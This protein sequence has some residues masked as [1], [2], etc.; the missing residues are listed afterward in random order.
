MSSRPTRP[1]LALLTISLL[2]PAAVLVRG[3]DWPDWRGPGRTGASPE[4][5]LVNTWSPTGQNLAWRVPY[6]GRSGPVVFGDRLYLQNTSGSGA[7]QQE[8]L[9]S[10]NADTGRLLWEHR[11]N[12]FTSDVPAHRVAWSSPVV[13]PT[14]GTVF[15]ISG[16]GLA[17]SLNK[18]GKVLWE[19]SL[20]EEYGMWTTHGGRMSTPIIEGDKMIVS[21]LVFGWGQTA[22]PAHRFIALDKT[23][24]QTI[25]VSS[26][27]GRPTD[28]IY[29]NPYVADVDGVRMFF[30][31]GSDGAMHALKVATGEPVWH[32]DVSKR[33]LNTAALMVGPDVIVTHS[34]ENLATSE[35]G[36]LAAVPA[37]SKGTLTDKDA[38][39]IVRDV[40]AGYGSPVSDGE[41]IYLVDNGGILFAF[42]VKTGKQ[43]WTEKL[44]TIQKSSPVLADGK[45]YVG[46]ENGKFYII[47]PHADKAEVL[48]SDQ[49][50]TEDSPEP[51]IGAPA[52]AR[53]RVYLT[54]MGATYA[55]GPKTAAGPA[56]APAPAAPA[57]SAPPAAGTP[58]T[59]L[60]TPTDLIVKPGDAVPLTIRA[61]DG[62]G[63]T[64]AAPA[65]E[66]SLDGLKGTVAGGKFT[67]DPAAGAQAGLVKATAGALSATS[68]IRVVPAPPWTF[69][70][71]DG[72]ETPPAY[73]VNATGKFAVRELD[74]S[75]VLV[76][77]AEN[78]FAFVK[79]CR[80]FFGGPELS[81]YTIQS[82]VRALERRRQMGDVGIVAQR[83]ELVLFG[84]HQRL[85]LQPWQ[86]ETERTARV[87]FT[88]TKDA[89]YTMKLEVQNMGGG[90]VRARGKVW[91]RGEAEPAAWTIER[92]DPIGNVKGA[93]GLYADAPSQAGGGSEL[94][95][96][97]IKVYGNKK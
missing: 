54:T 66:W 45:L 76:K 24:G 25:W 93:A 38:K 72:R 73:W 71:E 85:E 87:P 62:A 4:K 23:N 30:S 88:W 92:V 5:N 36:M 69:D 13:D 84:S 22:A 18:D 90:K 37:N 74:G 43:L 28:T 68:R 91:P 82:D 89:W 57:A 42:D 60:V 75:K 2:A 15:A 83:Y 48:D 11:Y 31:G 12:L 80:P 40:Q 58:T 34:E 50:G 79:R 94:Y 26:P 64:V 10:F 16:N 56:A 65:A 77:L 78:P 52:V 49:L 33:G 35:M 14:S 47:R 59:L 51:I 95:Y 17:M 9:M 19:R 6:G 32:W 44:G 67:P 3:A 21:G 27:E 97:N 70:F 29:A 86:P 8:R 96:D 41:R 81:D 7:M 20:V 53:G 61:F 1:L 55:I 39:W 63:R 46:T